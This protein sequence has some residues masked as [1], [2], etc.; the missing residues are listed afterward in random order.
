MRITLI[1]FA[2]AL[3]PISEGLNVNR[4]FNCGFLSRTLWTI[5]S[6][7]VALAQSKL[8]GVVE[9]GRARLAHMIAGSASDRSAFAGKSQRPL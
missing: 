6:K 9:T 8:V 2:F 1:K 7:A 5:P 4:P 3:A